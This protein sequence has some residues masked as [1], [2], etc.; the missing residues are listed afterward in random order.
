MAVAVKNDFHM[1]RIEAEGPDISENLRLGLHRTRIDHHMALIP[2]N[3]ERGE[4][5]RT[6][7]IHMVGNTDRGNWPAQTQQIYVKPS[8]EWGMEPS[9][10]SQ[11]NQSH[12]QTSQT[13]CH[14]PQ[15]DL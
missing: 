6:D 12:G 1:L 11:S 4:I 8:R 9:N 5:A 2:G 3:E 14:E 10:N 13:Y 7:M 15:P